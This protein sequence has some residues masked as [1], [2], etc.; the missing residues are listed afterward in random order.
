MDTDGSIIF[1]LLFILFIFLK[2]LFVLSET[3]IELLNDAKLKK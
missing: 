3:S 1:I 2:A